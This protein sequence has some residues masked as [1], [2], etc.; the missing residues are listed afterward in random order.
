MTAR[1]VL[2]ALKLDG[3]DF[4]HEARALRLLADFA[5]HVRAVERVRCSNAVRASRHQLSG[6]AFTVATAM[7][8]EIDAG[9]G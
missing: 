3:A 9:G 2:D 6:P 4:V 1:Q 7:L 8:A 5:G